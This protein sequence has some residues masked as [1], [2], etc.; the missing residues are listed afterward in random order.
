VGPSTVVA[1]LKR[2]AAVRAGSCDLAAFGRSDLVG[3]VFGPHR[4]PLG[5]SARAL[6][7][8]VGARRAWTPWADRISDRLGL[9]RFPSRTCAIVP[10][11][12][13]AFSSL[14]FSHVS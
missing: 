4:D 2:R 10:A 3:W 5:A 7:L 8:V 9:S 13:A 6:L 14:L 1:D 12:V 11:F